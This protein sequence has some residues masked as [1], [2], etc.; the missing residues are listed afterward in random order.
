MDYASEHIKEFSQ[1]LDSERQAVEPQVAEG[2]ELTEDQKR[3]IAVRR[4]E[5]NLK[6]L[7]E[8]ERLIA[9]APKLTFNSNVF[10]KNVHL[11]MTAEELAEEEKNVQNLATFINEKC[12]PNLIQ[13]L[14]Q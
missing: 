10:K 7:R 4:Q 1:K 3:E 6:K 13:D 8:V 14:K 11:D 2:E 12:I 9:E 5:D